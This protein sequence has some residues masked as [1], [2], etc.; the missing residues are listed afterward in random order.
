MHNAL[1]DGKVLKTSL[2][3]EFLLNIESTENAMHWKIQ[4]K[5]IIS[6]GI[7]CFL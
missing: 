1:F 7:Y 6:F 5:S 2:H 3:Y 4:N